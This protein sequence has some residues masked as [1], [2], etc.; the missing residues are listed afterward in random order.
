VRAKP[1]VVLA[2]ILAGGSLP[3]CRS[4]EITNWQQVQGDGFRFNA[5]AGWT[6]AG[7]VAKKGAVERVEV[8]TFRLQRP[9]EPSRR[10]AAA[11]ELDGVAARIAA[12]LKGTVT[13]SSSL[14]VSGLDARSYSI[15]YDG[16]MDELTFVLH[17]RREYELLCRRKAGSGDSACRELV[18]SFRVV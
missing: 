1:W 3:G 15:D 11:H 6:V 7:A 16:K 9:Y 13:E 8:L 17:D 14:E 10:E 12:Q 18:R 5:P 4:R 2:L